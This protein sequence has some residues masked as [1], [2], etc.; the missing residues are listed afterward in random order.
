[1][2]L[3]G[4]TRE[5]LTYLLNLVRKGEIPVDSY[6][7]ALV[8]ND[9][10]G[11]SAA[12]LDEPDAAE[13][14]R[15]E[16]VNDSANWTLVDNVLSNTAEITFPIAFSEWGSVN[17]WAI[18]DAPLDPGGRVLFSGALPEPIFIQTSYQAFFAPGSIGID[19]DGNQW[20][21]RL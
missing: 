13:Y 19:M 5:G 4:A 18:C 2:A 21:Q 9:A 14:V 10:P 17:Y 15:A 6:F 16:M 1:M 3:G 11:F 20:L 8:R 7:V 12:Q